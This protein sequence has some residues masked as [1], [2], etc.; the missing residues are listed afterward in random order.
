MTV[1][2]VRP[3]E[4]VRP[5]LVALIALAIL[6]A[7]GFGF[8]AA[9]A[10]DG[11]AVVT[12]PAHIHAGTCAE[13]DP[14]PAAPLNDVAPVGYSVEDG[15]YEDDEAPEVR[16]TLDAPPVLYSETEADIQ[17]DEVFDSSHAINVHESS[18]NIQN[19]IACGN[20][21]GPV[22]DDRVFVSLQ[23][24][25]DSGFFGIAIL[26]EADDDQTKVTIYLSQPVETDGEEP[27]DETP[28]P[29]PDATPDA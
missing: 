21:G 11:A 14:N 6:I 25:N 27:S 3:A 19:Y 13:L 23:P 8:G 10:Q 12:R 9:Q 4:G 18:E 28:T 29:A 16:G 26:E 2:S 5:R 24:Q 20:I 17:W 7:L 15:A 22:R 1:H